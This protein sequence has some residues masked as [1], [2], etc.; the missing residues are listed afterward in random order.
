MGAKN[1]MRKVRI[2]FNLYLDRLRQE[3]KHPFT[4][5]PGQPICIN[6]INFL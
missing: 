4:T 2:Q 3:V 1:E 5:S 6:A